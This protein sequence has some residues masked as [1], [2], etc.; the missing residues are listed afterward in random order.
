[1]GLRWEKQIKCLCHS[2]QFYVSYKFLCVGP[3]GPVPLL[4]VDSNDEDMGLQIEKGTRGGGLG[5]IS[6]WREA[7]LQIK[8]EW[9]PSF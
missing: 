6:T 8:S 2:D 7:S 4:N 9:S 5:S 3:C 1:M